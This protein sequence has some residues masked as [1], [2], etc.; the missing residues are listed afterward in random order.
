MTNYL[1][2]G[3]Q[4]IAQYCHKLRDPHATFEGAELHQYLVHKGL[5]KDDTIKSW[6]VRIA[7][8]KQ[9]KQKAAEVMSENTGLSTDAVNKIF[10]ATKEYHNPND[11]LYKTHLDSRV[12][13][14]KRKTNKRKRRRI[15]RSC[16]GRSFRRK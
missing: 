13:G 10:E 5:C 4:N 11:P 15:T 16:R 8:D 6:K 9:L 7:S 3:V 1:K 14:R 2:Q 12:G